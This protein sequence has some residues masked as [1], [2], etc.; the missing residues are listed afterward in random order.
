M[1]KASFHAM[2]TPESRPMRSLSRQKA[3][4]VNRVSMSSGSEIQYSSADVVESLVYF[5]DNSINSD[6]PLDS[7][8]VARNVAWESACT[9]RL[10][11]EIARMDALAE[12]ISEQMFEEDTNLLRDAFLAFPSFR[13]LLGLLRWIRW[14]NSEEIALKGPVENIPPSKSAYPTTTSGGDFE[15]PIDD[16]LRGGRGISSKDSER[17][18]KLCREIWDLLT[19]GRISDAIDRCT[20]CGHGWRAGVLNA[21]CGHTFMSEGEAQDSGLTDWVEGS[22]VAGFAGLASGV[23]TDSLYSR[24]LVKETAKA[25]LNSTEITPGIDVYDTAMIAYLCGSEE[26]M[27]KLC[28]SGSRKSFSLNLWVSLHCLKE[29]FAAF[30]LSNGSLISDRFQGVKDSEIDVVLGD[31][32]QVIMSSL[33]TGLCLESENQFQQLQVDLIQG[34]FGEVLSCLCDW[35][36]DGILRLNGVE[37]DVDLLSPAVDATAAVLI[38]SFSANLVT[39]LRN[40]VARHYRFEV[41]KVSAI[42]VANIESVVAQLKQ[43]ESLLEQNQVVVENLAL[44]IEDP[45]VHTTSWAWYLRQFQDD[46]WRG[47]TVDNS[48]SFAP[49]LSLIET[50]PQGA[51][52]VVKLLL[53]DAIDRRTESILSHAVGT[54]IQ[55]GRDV[56]FALGCVN[57]LWLT[58]QS[59]AKSTGN[60]IYLDVCGSPNAEDPDDAAASLV[61]QIGNL[62]GE[63]LLVLLLADLHTTRHVI[64]TSQSAPTG[65]HKLMSIQ[66]ALD[67]VHDG[68]ASGLDSLALVS[69]FVQILDRVTALME[70]NS[71]LEQQRANLSKL[72]GRARPMAGQSV[73]SAT[74]ARR[75]IIDAQRMLESSN[76]VVLKLADDIVMSLVELLK[77]SVCPIEILALE[78]NDQIVKAVVDVVVESCVQAIALVDDRKRHEVLVRN[79][80][81]CQW[82][83]S[84]IG[85]KRIETILEELV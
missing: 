21:A 67:S 24:Y 77:G 60:G 62:I 26:E 23:D 3:S 39:M 20:E 25:V 17:E 71:L 16:I 7:T 52:A 59:V 76:E 14:V 4:E 69:S 42:V 80:R 74:D 68:E 82:L 48:A 19:Q 18:R 75:Q 38:R 84:T 66:A 37:H 72:T 9:W 65:G 81:G 46:E 53:A 30:L 79:I 50:F 57:C 83:A 61:S 47:W 63:G 15:V 13:R 8:Q 35:T 41:T 44:L 73:A 22:I 40:V 56:A 11:L 12:R 64:N 58:T 2:Y 34:N 54:S 28:C 32:I 27:K 33:E 45:A 70:R 10:L 51:V 55:A 6:I 85:S 31:S 43:S 49:I 36:T 1:V 29:E 5:Y 78:L